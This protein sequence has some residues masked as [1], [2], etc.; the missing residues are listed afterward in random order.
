MIRVAIVGCGNLGRGAEAAL[1]QNPDMELVAIFSRRDASCVCISTECA[2]V[3]PME[4][5]DRLADQIDVLILCGGSATDLPEMTPALAAKFNVIDSFDNHSHIPEHIAAVEAAAKKA[6]T[7]AIVSCGWDPGLFSLMRIYSQAALPV[8]ES[9]TFWGPGLSQGHSDAIRRIEGVRDARQYTIPV[10]ESLEKVRR[11]ENP[12]LTTR[13]KHTRQCFV[14]PWKD[15]DLA[16]I[17][18]EIKEMPGYFADYDTTV[19]F[20]TQ[21]E[22]DENH[23]GMPHGGCVLRSGTTQL[24]DKHTV[25]FSLQLESNPQFTSSILVSCARA[26]YRMHQRGETGCFT[27]PEVR[28]CDLLPQSIEEIRK[29]LI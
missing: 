12:V 13:Q 4:E 7:T 24:G 1:R 19:T 21:Q 11:G 17:E 14:V 20:I 26:A 22:L 3:L 9:Y 15:A 25:E 10:E 23:A 18:R 6:G 8:G 27:M 5:L 29:H 2:P 16:R 28:P